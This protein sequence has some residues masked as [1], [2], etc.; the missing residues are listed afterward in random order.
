MSEI[1]PQIETVSSTPVLDSTQT[2]T[3]KSPTPST[4]ARLP[5]APLP[6]MALRV[7][8]VL[9][10]AVSIA[11]FQRS[12]YSIGGT[13]DTSS[14]TK[15][16]GVKE[17]PWDPKLGGTVESASHALFSRLHAYVYTGSDQLSGMWAE[18]LSTLVDEAF[19]A[20]RGGSFE[21][22]TST[23]WIFRVAE[24]DL[25]AGDDRDVSE[26]QKQALK[27]VKNEKGGFM[28]PRATCLFFSDDGGQFLSFAWGSNKDLVD[29]LSCVKVSEEE[30]VCLNYRYDGGKVCH[31]FVPDKR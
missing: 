23:R 11:L 9:V 14:D 17:T 18:R 20:G 8:V 19:Q 4:S 13:K 30:T 7:I 16:G 29:S 15:F 31:N 25:A 6:V 22:H 1:K 10:V 21:I 28:W 27:L 2:A 3:A 24:C 5:N 12:A 26:L